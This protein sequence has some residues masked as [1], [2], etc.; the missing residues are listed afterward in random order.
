MPQTMLRLF[1]ATAA[2]AVLAGLPGAYA[3][4]NPTKEY[5]YLGGRVVATESPEK[6]ATPVFSLAA[7]TYT[8][9]RT[10]TIST[11]TVGATIR[12]STNGTAPTL[13]TGYAYGGEIT[14]SSTQTL[15]AYAYLSGRPDSD[16]ASAAYVISSKAAKPVLSVDSG[17]YATIFTV[18]ITTASSGA[19]IHYTTDST[20]PTCTTGQEYSIPV[21]IDHAQTLTAIACGTG[22]TDSD[23]ASATYTLK[24][25]TP[26][27]SVASGSYPST[28][29]VTITTA[30][31]PATI[32]YTTD[33]TAPTCTTGHEYSLA[34]TVDHALTITAIACATGFTNSN[35][36]S[37]AYVLKVGKPVFSSPS[38]THT[39]AFTVTIST[40]T[41]GAKIYYTTNGATPTSTTGQEY[42]TS[43]VTIPTSL[44][45]QAR[46][47]KSGFDDSDVETAAYVISS[48]AT[49]KITT[50]NGGSSAYLYNGD[51][52]QLNAY[53]NGST[54][55]TNNLVTWTSS[56]LS[57][58]TVSSSGLCTAVSTAFAYGA[59]V[60]ATLNSNPSI[61]SRV[62]F[63]LWGLSTERMYQVEPSPAVDNVKFH[64]RAT[65]Q[66][67]YSFNIQYIYLGTDPGNLQTGC[68]ITNYSGAMISLM[69]GQ[70]NNPVQLPGFY[71][72]TV[73]PYS[74]LPLSGT[75][76]YLPLDKVYGYMSN[77]SVSE[78]PN[79]DRVLYLPIRAQSGFSGEVTI[80]RKVGETAP[81]VNYATWTIPVRANAPTAAPAGGTYDSS[82]LVSL[83]STTANALI[84]YTLDG[85]TPP[86][87]TDTLYTGPITIAQSK[88]LKAVAYMD[89]TSDATTS[90]VTTEVFGIRS[91]PPTILPAA[92]LY[93]SAR[94]VTLSTTTA[95]ATIYYTLN[96]VDPTPTTGT[97]YNTAITVSSNT[98]V[99]AITSATGYADS[100]VASATYTFDLL[101]AD[102]VVPSIPVGS[103]TFRASNSITAGTNVTASSTSMA[104]FESGSF[105]R[106]QPGFHATAGTGG[107]VFRAFI[108]PLLH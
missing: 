73:V 82:R 6:V 27:L 51:Q 42:T 9:A 24:A 34:V 97:R 102:L 15:M 94:S 1:A 95:G 96:G 74:V 52:L 70:P 31:P 67:T 44:T 64:W 80:F 103:T 72:T 99:K 22:F 8:S 66:A 56:D 91:V 36:A 19:K 39:A 50:P 77:D 17:T 41:S 16:V 23:P 47:F 12:Y 49:L 5:I 18:S 68:T 4:S 58:V 90:A 33:G 61:S 76:C 32:H 2:F 26:V 98:T 108:N 100:A 43:G 71:D 86:S 13:T 21:S 78:A 84:R 37:S 89:G 38:G 107:T 29:T 55:A 59:Y 92:G 83:S 75:H 65:N 28:F 93:S 11:A 45:L 54:T 46:A 79:F 25:G 53:I 105:V 35:T 69:D 88:T 3:Q 63:T 106:L 7:G 104:T 101:T 14:V 10:V 81:Y 60:T 30:T 48:P 40:A 85:T 20:T 87:S 57:R 62:Y